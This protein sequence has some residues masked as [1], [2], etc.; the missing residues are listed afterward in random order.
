M[1]LGRSPAARNDATH[2]EGNGSVTTGPRQR[3]CASAC[4][5]R[6]PDDWPTVAL[7]MVLDAGIWTGDADFRGCGLPTWAT[8]TL[9]AE[10]TRA[11]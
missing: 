9:P 7:A 1:T 10:V 2:L 11:S 3:N 5:P 6:D 8:D 4:V